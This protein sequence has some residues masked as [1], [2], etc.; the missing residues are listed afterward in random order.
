VTNHGTKPALAF[1]PFRLDVSEQVLLRDGRK[2]RLTPKVLSV[3]HVL[4]EHRGRLVDKETLLQTVW[5]DSFVEEGAL[6]RSVSVLRKALGDTALESQYI[7]TVPKRG[8]RF[9]AAVTEVADGTGEPAIASETRALRTKWTAGITLALV[10]TAAIW[11][12]AVRSSVARVAHPARAADHRQVTFTG[13]AGFPTLSHDGAHVAYISDGP[14]EKKVMVQAL[15]GGAPGAIFSAPE[16]GYLSWSPDATELLVWARGAGKDGVYVISP[17][18]AP[19]HRIVGNQYVSCWSPDGSTIAVGSYLHGRIVFFTHAGERGRTVS[20]EH[21]TGSI[22]SLDWS[23]AHDRLV[24]VSSDDQGHYAVWTV[25]PNGDE[26]TRLFVTDAEIPSARWSSDGDAIYYFR[27]FNQTVSLNKLTLPATAGDERSATTLL[28]GLEP[29]RSFAVSADATRLVYARAP[30]YSNLWVLDRASARSG[31]PHTTQLTHGTSRIERPRLSP[32]GTSIVFNMGQQPTAHLYTMPVHG[33]SFKQ[34][35]FGDSFNVGGAWSPDGTRIAFASTRGGAPRVWVMNADGESPRALSSGP[36]S[37]TFDLGWFPGARLLYQRPGNLNYY[38]LDPATRDETFFVKEPSPGWIF[39]PAYSPDGRS[40]AVYWN[41]FPERG[42]WT[43]DSRT[44]RETL[45]LRTDAMPL[46][47]S[48]DGTSIYALEGKPG[49]LRGPPLPSGATTIGARI[50]EV[51][52]DGSGVRPVASLP[53]QEIGT[54]TVAPD[55][56]KFY[57]T[58]YT[59]RSDVWIVDNFDSSSYLNRRP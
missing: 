53:A 34:L 29:D 51:R 7:E 50:V 31:A 49:E 4:V 18:G 3:L 24:V 5:A 28:S 9:I 35:T 1:G 54:V 2:V 44:R 33:G 43:I 57:Y 17:L 56:L 58:V 30:Y 13:H 32:D 41:R 10:A 46:G 22:W 26:Q 20:L 36:M 37:E 11:Y 47:W 25:R 27:R 8:Y 45:I 12:A 42:I 55:G 21:V 14:G 39:S 40:V 59:S 15:A 16:L 19:P 6:N 23:P 38:E 52:V 48:A